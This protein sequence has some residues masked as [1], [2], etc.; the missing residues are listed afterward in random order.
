MK[1]NPWTLGL[2]ALGVVSLA[3]VVQAEEKTSPLETA[4]SKTII[5]GYVDTSAVWKLG[6]DSSGVAPGA[7]RI[8]GR[9]FDNNKNDGFNLNVVKISIE[10]P[11]DDAQWAAGYK[12]DLLFG[13]DAVGWNPSV[14]SATGAAAANSDFA[15]KQA[16]VA[17]RAPVGNGLD[18]KMGVFDSPLGY[19]V[20]EAGNNQN[21]S[22]SYGYGMEPSEHTGLLASYKINDIVSVSAGVANTITTGINDRAVRGGFSPTEAEKTYMGTVTLTAPE[23]LG[24]LK[25]STLTAGIVNGLDANPGKPVANERDT[26]HIYVGGTFNTPVTGL[27][28]GAAWD[29]REK[30]DRDGA[31]GARFSPNVTEYAVAG[32]IVYQA[33]EKLKLANRV[34][35]YNGDQNDP[36]VAQYTPSGTTYSYPTHQWDDGNKLMSVTSTVDYSLWANVVSRLEFRWDHDL[37]GQKGTIPTIAAPPAGP[38]GY[39]DNNAFTVALNVIYK[40]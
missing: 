32:Y 18:F 33:T 27:T 28:L 34:D 10:K 29:F 30:Q 6:K 1:L 3:S 8:L 31:L 26:T 22:R 15:L 39:D 4:I 40:F 16:Y 17:L 21:Y 36:T 7:N 20:F 37:T 24:F 11:L 12:A 14:S 35:F 38:F 2:V 19:E 9:S 13:P 5:S 25:G 23:S